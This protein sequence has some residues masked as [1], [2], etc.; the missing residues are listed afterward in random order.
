ES[1]NRCGL[2]GSGLGMPA[3]LDGRSWR[4]KDWAESARRNVSLT[5]ARP[6]YVP[7]GYALRYR[8]VDGMNLAWREWSQSSLR[9]CVRGRAAL[10]AQEMPRRHPGDR[11]E[12]VGE[13]GLVAVAELG[14]HV[15]QSGVPGLER[16]YRVVQA[17]AL[18]QPLGGQPHPLL[19]QT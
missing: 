14:R 12:V 15:G 4:T 18:D 6:N 8:V 19:H 16:L 11:A 3:V 17:P 7:A 9:S 2:P 5:T 13:V 10:V 1:Q